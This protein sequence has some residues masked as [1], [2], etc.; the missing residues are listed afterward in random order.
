MQPVVAAVRSR[1]TAAVATKDADPLM[2]QARE[3]ADQYNKLSPSL[4][5]RRLKIGYTKAERLLELLQAEGYGDSDED[6][7]DL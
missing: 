5:Q 4:L 7:D 2:P 3:L 1:K 6:G